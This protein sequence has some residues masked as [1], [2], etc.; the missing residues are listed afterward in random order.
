MIKEQGGTL[1]TIKISTEK[2]GNL[3]GTSP[4]NCYTTFT[5]KKQEQ[6]MWSPDREKHRELRSLSRTKKLYEQPVLEKKRDKGI[7]LNLNP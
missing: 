5:N 6:G 1:K 4:M 2:R 3:V 7:C